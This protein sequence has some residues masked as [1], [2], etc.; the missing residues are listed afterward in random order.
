VQG[1]SKKSKTKLHL[2]GCGNPLSSAL[3]A[4]VGVAMVDGL[5]WCRTYFCEPMWL[6]HLQHEGVLPRAA[7]EFLNL[8]AKQLLSGA[9]SYEDKVAIHNLVALQSF[10]IALSEALEANSLPE[11]VE[12]TYGALPATLIRTLLE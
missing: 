10:G 3:F 6:T 8:G 11:F 9:P 1:L 12:G 4:A 5:E 7:G 2:L